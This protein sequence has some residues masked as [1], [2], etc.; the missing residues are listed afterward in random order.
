MEEIKTAADLKSQ[1]LLLE[2]KRSEELILLKAQFLVTYENLRPLNLIKN[3]LHELIDTPDPKE[4]LLTNTLSV[5][6]GFIS[7]KIVVG[8]THNPIKQIL[9]T[10][11][12]M[13]VSKLIS[14][15]SE[16]IRSVASTLLNTFLSK[17]E[18]SS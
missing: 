8:N 11:L 5:A 4:D 9:G 10:V 14:K 12:Q 2:Y 13:A 16:G 18:T 15:N 6:A 17:K 3:T 1:I 7:K